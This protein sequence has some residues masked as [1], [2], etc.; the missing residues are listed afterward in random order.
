MSEVNDT[1][2]FELDGE[3]YELKYSFKMV[4][5]LRNEGINVPAIYRAISED[6]DSAGDYADDFTSIAAILLREA[7]ARVN[8]QE[9]WASCNADAEAMQS[10]MLLFW[11][12]V[13]N[14]YAGPQNVKK[15]SLKKK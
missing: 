2:S 8:E 4:R 14:H 15:Y 13:S 12:V 3:E 9:L 5:K 11:W 10:V 1:F 7:G 6:K